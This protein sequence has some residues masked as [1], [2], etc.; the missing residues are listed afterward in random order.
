MSDGTHLHLE[1]DPDEITLGQLIKLEG[2]TSRLIR[3][4]GAEVTRAP[5]DA[6]RWVVESVRSGSP[7]VY[8]LRPTADQEQIPP[9]ILRDAVAAITAG[10]A[11]LAGDASSR[12]KF[13]N[14]E[15]L[16]RARDLGN[17]LGDRVRAVTF[18]NGNGPRA[19]VTKRT[20]ANVE[21]ILAQDEYEALGTVEGRLEAVNVHSRNYFN[22][23]EDLTGRRVECQFGSGIPVEEI[24]AAIG[25]R[26]GVYGILVSRESGR[27]VRVRVDE[28]DVFPD[29]DHLPSI[30][31]VEGIAAS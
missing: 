4:V 25:K 18:Y 5:R 22:V 11:R 10:M 16:E 30:D 6:I 3:E 13:F 19:E 20:V 27:V 9:A 28:V 29:P 1:I 21:A 24:G 14:D 7:I 26:V 31:D 8:E 12:P 15:A 2:I 17:E 23:Y